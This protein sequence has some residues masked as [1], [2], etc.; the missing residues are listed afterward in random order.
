MP[1][2]GKMVK[3]E[4]FRK[5]RLEICMAEKMRKIAKYE[6]FDKAGI[7]LITTDKNDENGRI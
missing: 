5:A 7:E 1:C 6:D 2:A 3:Y 4:D